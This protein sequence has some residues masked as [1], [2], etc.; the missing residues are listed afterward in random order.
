MINRLKSKMSKSVSNC[1]RSK[2]EVNREVKISL[3]QRQRVREQ[4]FCVLTSS[5]SG[6]ILVI[7]VVDDKMQTTSR[8]SHCL[9]KRNES[10][11]DI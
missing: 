5:F 1:Y 4:N 11:S 7:F 2:S 8:S 9:Q 6:F 3:R 10:D